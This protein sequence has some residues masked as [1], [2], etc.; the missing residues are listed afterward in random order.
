MTKNILIMRHGKAV[1]GEGN[2]ADIDRP[3]APRGQEDVAKVA[4]YLGK[5]SLTPQRIFSSS[6]QRTTETTRIIVNVLGIPKSSVQFSDKLYLA[7]AS[8]YLSFLSTLDDDISSVMIV[9]HNPGVS[10]CVSHLTEDIVDLKTSAVAH[11]TFKGSWGEIQEPTLQKIF[12]PKMM[13][14]YV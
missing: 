8:T 6:S 11:I 4:A 5:R 2:V 10:H 9:G 13:D 1:P 3:L 7:P 14:D 12:S